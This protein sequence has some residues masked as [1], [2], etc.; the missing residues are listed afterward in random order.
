MF[1]LPRVGASDVREMHNSNYSSFIFS[2]SF[3]VKPGVI[4]QEVSGVLGSMVYSRPF[5]NVGYYWRR[6]LQGGL[7]VE[8]T[9]VDRSIV[10]IQLL[11][12][13]E[14]GRDSRDDMLQ[15]AR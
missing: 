3:L 11:R 12:D 13:G 10:E 14:T 9:S 6:K 2:C 5:L 1:A 15:E 4:Y 7:Y 8:V